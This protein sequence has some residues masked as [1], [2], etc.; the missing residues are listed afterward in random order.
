ML[1]E[2]A[3]DNVEQRSAAALA[4][5]FPKAAAAGKLAGDRYNTRIFLSSYMIKLHPGVVL[6]DPAAPTQAALQRAARSQL[7]SF[8]TLLACLATT[9]T[10]SEAAALAHKG[11]NDDWVAYLELF[12]AWKLKDA[13]ALSCCG[14]LCGNEAA[15]AR[16]V[17]LAVSAKL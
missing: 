6:I 12:A 4:R 9:C 17:C 1:L 10:G 16:V 11:W 7:A 14:F 15:T 5:L 13:A 2:S 3:S 8:D